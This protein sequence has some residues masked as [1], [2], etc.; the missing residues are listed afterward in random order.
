[1][2][3]YAGYGGNVTEAVSYDIG[4]LY[5]AYPEDDAN[6]DLDYQ[7]FYGS[8]SI[9][10]AT[11][12]IAYSND[13]FAETDA[14]WYL[15]GE[16]ELSPVENLTLGVHLGLN[17]FD[18]DSAFASFIGPAAGEDP[19]D[20]YLDWS[21]SA[22]TEYYGVEWGLAFVGTDLNQDECFAGTKLCD[23]TLVLSLTKSL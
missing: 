21:L 9:A 17:K 22:S 5:Y 1:M 2:D 23:N 18:S 13:Y 19:G 14:F 20:S 8:V 6:P 15:Y 16:Y 4:Y 7:E 10:D 12:G 3:F 11:L